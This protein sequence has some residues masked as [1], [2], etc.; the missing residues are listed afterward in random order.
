M[1]ESNLTHSQLQIW[2]GQRLS[3]D[4]PLYNM[5]F[6]YLFEG[7][8]RTDVFR[9]AWQDVVDD[10]D[11]LRTVVDERDG[12]GSGRL[13]PLGSCSTEIV[14]WRG[15]GGSEERFTS[16]CRDRCSRPLK[17]DETLVDSVLVRLPDHRTGW[18]LNQHHLI[19]DAASTVLLYRSV[20]TRYR[21]LLESGQDPPVAP[22]YYSV[23]EKLTAEGAAR[24][25]A[26]EH[27]SSRQP[28][29]RGAAGL[30]G[31]S[32]EPN[33][34]SS[35]RLTVEL[36]R[37]QQRGIDRLCSEPGWRSL[38]PDL[39]RFALLATLL[40]A[41][42][43]RVTGR[44]DLGFDAP[45]G[46][47]PTSEAKR[48]LGLFIEMFPFATRVE[49]DDSFRTL[50]ARCLEEAQL[51]LRHALPGTSSPSAS[52]SNSIVL[53]YV[54]ESF[55][56]FSG[57]APQVEW[58]HPGHGDRLHVLRLQA[59]DFSGSGHLTLHFDFNAGIF[60]EEQCQ[61]AVHHCM[62]LLSALIEDADAKVGEI[63]LL[64]EA[65][66][67]ELACLDASASTSAPERTVVQMFEA[68]VDETPESIAL[69][70][71]DRQM[72]FLELDR[73]SRA[74]AAALHRRITGREAR[75][76]ILARRSISAV[77]AI[78]GV[79][80][81]RAAYVPIDPSA[82]SARVHRIVTD[83]EAEVLLLGEEVDA[84]AEL[85]TP[86]LGVSECLCEASLGQLEPPALD[87]LA[88]LLYTSGSTGR[89][90]GVL[91]EH[92]GL[93]DYLQWASA[94]Y[95]RGDRL[96]YPLFTSLSF[97]LTVTS[98][99]LPL[100]TGGTLEIFPEPDG[101]VDS[102]V[103]EVADRNSVDFIKLTPS[104]LSL[105][106]QR[107]L[108]GSRIRR[109]VVGGEDLRSRLADSVQRQLGDPA[110]I[111]N[112]YGPTE[113]VV[114]CCVHRYRAG[115]DSATSVPIGRP[116]DGV[117]LQVLTGAGAR[118][119]VGV[120][121]EL[122]ISR[123]GLARGYHRLDELTASRFRP[124]PQRPGD[125]LYRSGD[126][127][128]FADGRLEFLGRTDRQIKISGHRLEPGEIETVLLSHPDISDSVVVARRRR[129]LSATDPTYCIRC[130]LPSNYPRAAFDESGL[131]GV[132]RTYSSIRANAE[133]YFKGMDELGA[134]FADSATSNRSGYDCMMLLSGGKDSTYA[135]CTLV[136]MGLEVYAFTLDNG[137]ISEG[138]KDNM[139][140]VTEQLGVEH[141]LATTAAMSAIFRDS[142]E[143]FSN[144]CHGCFKTIYTLS[145]NRAR[146]LGIPIIVTGLSRGQMFETRLTQE[147]FRDD[148]ISPDEVDAAV[149]AA[150]KVY[151]RVDDQVA[152]SLDVEAFH[153]DEVFEQVRFVDFYRY[154]DVGLAEVLD[155][156]RAR[157][158]WVRPADT[159]RSTNCLINDIGIY[160]HKLE[161]GYHN[162]A[163]PYSWDVR[164]GHKSREEALTELNDELDLDHVHRTLDQI[165][166]RPIG[167][168]SDDQTT[169]AAFYVSAREVS[170]ADLRRHLAERLP[171]ALVPATLQRIERVPLNANGKLDEQA[172]PQQQPQTS[173][174]A[175]LVPLEG[176]VEEYLASVWQEELGVGAVGATDN[177]FELGGT[178]LA[179]M[180]IMLRLCREFHLDLA[181]ETI[182][183]HPTLRQLAGVAEDRILEDVAA[184]D[185]N[186]QERLLGEQ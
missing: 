122:H 32:D 106:D 98:L 112:E 58:L 78:L 108:S 70:Q 128:R 139:R 80:R 113:A 186:R 61:R 20:A 42:L 7:E 136:D 147:M 71:G 105:L 91:I 185:A 48:S 6:A 16:W 184:L 10:S 68:Q 89:P 73:D 151:H 27:W 33:G 13:L 176:P 146:E 38:S 172:L 116:A 155:Y 120:P 60:S 64:T 18:Y 141:E 84:M 44:R 87:D 81:A 30:Y 62:R 88:Y 148:R 150:R 77:V 125:R 118:A 52:S 115:R 102:S 130:G 166:Y 138:A 23:A 100:I 31:R 168:E 119:P 90:K 69:R 123:T 43:H 140:R 74:V 14:D 182:F 1:L 28:R 45:I 85:E 37:R 17:L 66:I 117:E 86:Q 121:G 104:H 41:W 157:V 156:L 95:A 75:V 179:A 82:P 24:A 159:G 167:R 178:S 161:R 49:S 170:E 171:R 65:E 175:R 109:M 173:S 174:A 55:G 110:E 101:P 132:C 131:C 26:V 162:Y 180:E 124:H 183:E 25:A 163:L 63:E 57:I 2:I 15:A 83:S 158:P 165:G 50:G 35:R 181:L 137:F 114:G 145:T 76:A 111:D 97:D 54:P 59:H 72:S 3:P 143:R 129:S 152:R 47:R 142:L 39:S 46:G 9:R 154:C 56:D 103:L 19:C 11:A 8:L 177:F 92:R 36:D 144:V 22:S 53:N 5:A 127:V 149:L 133:A 99:F 160:V 29:A 164:L 79:L 94:R 134:L 169:L 135:L 93:A 126:L 107:G 12:V 51:F 40:S 4:S 67:E 96:T 153:S 34:T 21:V